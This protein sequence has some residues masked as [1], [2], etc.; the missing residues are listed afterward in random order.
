[1]YVY[2]PIYRYL[3]IYIYRFVATL[4]QTRS[5]FKKKKQTPT[6]ISLALF[7]NEILVSKGCVCK[8]ERMLATKTTQN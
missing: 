5:L 6:D 2:I 8:K 7:C 4:F 3:G 1:M